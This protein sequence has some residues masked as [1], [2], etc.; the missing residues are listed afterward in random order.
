MTTARLVSRKVAEAVYFLSVLGSVIVSLLFVML[1]IGGLSIGGKLATAF[2]PFT[3]YVAVPLGYA[4][5]AQKLAYRAFERERLRHGSALLISPS[6]GL[7][8]QLAVPF[9][10][11]GTAS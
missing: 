10:L 9:Y 4:F 1:M 3:L 6:L 8:A 7:A 2:G 5:V 11:A